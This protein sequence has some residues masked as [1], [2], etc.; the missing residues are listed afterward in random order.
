MYLQ[1]RIVNL[2]VTVLNIVVW[3]GFM[4]VALTMFIRLP[5][6][7][8]PLHGLALVW[9]IALRLMA[10]RSVSFDPEAA[11]MLYC[12]DRACEALL[13]GVNPYSLTYFVS[14]SHSFP[15]SYTPLA[16]LP[17]LPFKLVG[18]DIRW[19]NLLAQ[20]A[21]FAFLF[22]LVG[23]DN[24]SA[25]R[26][27]VPIVLILMPD[28]IWTFFYRQMSHYWLLGVLFVWLISRDRWHSAALVLAGMV[29]IRITAL[30]TVWMFLI[31]VWKRKGLRLAV[32][33]GVVVGAAFVV[34]L[35]PFSGVGATR[36]KFVF[37]DRYYQEVATWQAP[38]AT[39]SV[40]GILRRIGLGQFILALQGGGLVAMG[41][42][43]RV[44]GSRSFQRF[45]TLSALA[46]AYFMWLSGVVYIYYWFLPIVM[47]CTLY[48]IESGKAEGSGTVEIEERGQC[49]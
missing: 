20:L 27:A 22:R 6:S 16:W 37:F 4:L 24:R 11:D 38:L 29:S 48:L 17:Y 47:L 43:Y 39:L 28:M 44:A 23:R 2:P 30:S 40:G 21:L 7:Y 25:M 32:V 42:M 5:D 15:L 10:L 36:L 33:Y 34:F 45:T 18:L 26:S 35:L 9:G 13:R 46:Y 41:A 3:V 49:G 14:P 31:Y 8:T 1:M 19:F 12:I